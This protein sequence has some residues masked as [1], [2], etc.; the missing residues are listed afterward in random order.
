VPRG[1]GA[2]AGARARDEHDSL[3]WHRRVLSG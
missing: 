2:D 3:V 1:G